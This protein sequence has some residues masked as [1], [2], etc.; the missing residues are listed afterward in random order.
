MVKLA[1]NNPAKLITLHTA[2]GLDA[3]ATNDREKATHHYRE[4]LG[5]YLDNWNE[6]DLAR[7][8]IIGFRKEGS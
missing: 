1:S 4:A 8:R 3:E 5:T 6:Y 2:L 7:A